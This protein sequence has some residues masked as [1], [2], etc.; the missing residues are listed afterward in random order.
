MLDKHVFPP[1][2][3]D[4]VHLY[5]RKRTQ[6]EH[7][8]NLNQLEKAA[9]II[10]TYV[11]RGS[12]A[13]M[14]LKNARNASILI[15][16][17]YRAKKGALEPRR[18]MLLAARFSKQLEREEK[19]RFREMNKLNNRADDGNNHSSVGE[20]TSII[21]ELQME[22]CKENIAV[23]EKGSVKLIK[24]P[25]GWTCL[26]CHYENEPELK[27]CDLCLKNRPTAWKV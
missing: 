6:L 19:E 22:L 24:I 23:D 18:E 10:Q 20:I 8:T 26:L 16:T 1:H 13:R 25:G 5:E 17:F 2:C 27:K 3:Q 14:A 11:F 15:Q 7:Q 12:T 9:T 21:H 4:I